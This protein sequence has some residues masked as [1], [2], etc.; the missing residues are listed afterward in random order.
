MEKRLK[1]IEEE[2][3]KSDSLKEK[4]EEKQIKLADEQIKTAKD[5]DDAA[6]AGEK[7]S[8]DKKPFL[9]RQVISEDSKIRKVGQGINRFAIN[10]V[11]K[12]SK[13]LG[14]VTSGAK[15][16]LNKHG[17]KWLLLI[18][19]ALHWFDVSMNLE[20]TGLW[21]T[22][23]AV[24]YLVLALVIAP[25]LI[26]R[27]FAGYVSGRTIAY[28][29]ISVLSWLM[30]K[31]LELFPKQ[32]TGND[33]FVF[34]LLIT[35]FWGAF[36]M[37]YA[38]ESDSIESK[39]RGVW[40]GIWIVL[41]VIILIGTVSKTT[42]PTQLQGKF[43]L[44]VWKALSNI[45][46]SLTDN[47]TSILQR[48]GALPVLASTFIK[49]N[50]NDTLGKSYS[51]TVDEH[52]Q[53]ELGV[54]FKNLRAQDQK[55][56]KGA[57]VVVWT[58]I[59]GEA[60]NDNLILGLNCFAID[61]DGNQ[62][63]GTITAQGLKTINRNGVEQQYLNITRKQI[64]SAS[65]TFDELPAGY[66]EIFFHGIFNFETWAYVEYYFA[67]Y[68]MIN[69]LW[70]DERDPEDYYG[71]DKHPIAKYNKGP[72]MLGLASEADQPIPLLAESGRESQFL[73]AFGASI[74]NAW[75]EGEVIHVESIQLL[76]PPPFQLKGCDRNPKTGDKANPG[77]TTDPD[78]NYRIFEFEGI[79]NPNSMFQSTTCLVSLE[80]A[81]EVS[82]ILQDFDL[83]QK[84]FVG[85]TKYL[86]AIK[87]SIRVE[88]E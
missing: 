23:W 73:P 21:A 13:G 34:L 48:L 75:T 54:E 66:Y 57:P 72:V 20:R 7:A 29:F 39:I 62:I 65:C 31:I 68:D 46:H 42:V 18:V 26:N 4:L 88:V 45:W 16:H 22:V 27:G 28:L 74:Q 81:R 38:T 17:T 15:D 70:Q 49:T 63:K 19:F 51:G 85:K 86:Y 40:L 84:T 64:T 30:P 10:P 50:L 8:K 52:S 35:P 9:K 1:E 33:Y 60:F 61:K 79:E 47:L 78:T 87:D 3:A 43:N 82:D 56:F 25:I 76:V 71:I 24:V 41:M 58:D 55:F 67:P 14:S 36:L 6:K 5:Q 77:F 83:V 11:V 59:Q 12:V 69:V 2:S 44:N 80:S 53:T 32:V 37:F